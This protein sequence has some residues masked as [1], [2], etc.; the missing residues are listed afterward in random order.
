MGV[1]G[2]EIRAPPRC[3]AA[4]VCSH[5]TSCTTVLFAKKIRNGPTSSYLA[6]I[7]SNAHNSRT[8]YGSCLKDRAHFNSLIASYAPCLIMQSVKGLYRK[9]PI[10]CLASS[11]ILTPH[12]LTARR[13]CTPPPTP[14]VRGGG[15]TRW[16][17]RGWG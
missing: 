4:V 2:Q 10:Q 7:S 3:V 17:E 8:V 16:V 13:V 6:L 9:R 11:E 15:H 12:P 5:G 14:L 1:E